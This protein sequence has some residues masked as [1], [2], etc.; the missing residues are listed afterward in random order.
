VNERSFVVCIVSPNSVDLELAAS[1][2]AENGIEAFGVPDLPTAAARL[3]ESFGCLL[4]VE[5]ALLNEHIPTLRD[6]LARM[7]SWCDLPLLVVSRDVGVFGTLTASAFPNSGNV[8]LL[9]RP[10]HPHSLV[11]AVHMALRAMGRQRQLAQLIE[12]R[13]R[14][15]KLR[16]EFLAMLAH[17][18]R[19]PLAPMRN[20]IYLMRAT[21]QD[22]LALRNIDIL[23]RQVKHVVRMV[24]DLMDVARLERGKVV[25]QRTPVDLNAIVAAVVESCMPMVQERGHRIS[26]NL[27]PNSLL[28]NADEV[29]IEQIIT[30]LITNAVKFTRQPDE[31]RVETSALDGYATI[32]VTD[33]GI[34][35][36]PAAAESLF[37][38]F[39]PAHPTLERT[40][41]GLGLGLTIVKRLAELHGGSV[42]ARS[43]GPGRGATFEFRM[44]LAPGAAATA[45]HKVS[46]PA[47]PPHRQ[48]VVVVED[49]PDIRETFHMLLT[50]WG[51]EV[52]LAEDGPSGLDCV[53]RTKPDVA[54]IDVGLPEMNGYDVARAI[55]REIPATKTRLV[56]VTGYGQS[57]DRELAF[58]AG[59]DMHLLKP[60]APETLEA[61]LAR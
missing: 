27:A 31:I 36:D 48:R 19:N 3:D 54:L 16:D 29:R 52:F 57:P 1:F 44:P 20:S 35:F 34:G 30:N 26:L 40:A 14:D 39:L 25:L 8:T 7:P 41:G 5:E 10:L 11:S 50:M 60:V 55:R 9:E 22:P 18:L 24:D 6:A 45:P 38:P 43:E 32:R 46:T 33:R 17:E 21:Q 53:L 12:Q 59:F 23:D 2:L 13:E 15:L 58:K 47:L 61:L 42:H 4:L 28:A 49:N 51:H 37:D 56:A